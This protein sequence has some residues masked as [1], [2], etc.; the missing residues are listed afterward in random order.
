MFAARGR[1]IM[2][3]AALS[4]AALAGGALCA[5]QQDEFAKIKEAQDAISSLN[6]ING[7]YLTKDQQAGL[8]KYNRE[9]VSL[10]EDLLNGPDVQ[11]VKG[12]SEQAL[13]ELKQYLVFHPEQEDSAV[14]NKAAKAEK[15]YTD[16]VK[17]RNNQLNKE[18]ARIVKEASGS[19]L[20]SRWKS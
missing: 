8:L 12:E 18:Y 15:A 6:L 10:R 5:Q 9:M 4:I 2:A 11:K 20:L 3:S 16:L 1:K 7:L 17:E 13:T 14:Q 19:S